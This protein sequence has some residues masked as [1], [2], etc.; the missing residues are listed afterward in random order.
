MR[1]IALLVSLVLI[2]YVSWLMRLYTVVKPVFVLQAPNVSL[3]M[4]KEINAIPPY[5]IVHVTVP[6]A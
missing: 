3:Q 2:M 1:V 6:L 5:A 4:D